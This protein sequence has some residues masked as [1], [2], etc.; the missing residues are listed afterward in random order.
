MPWEQE[1]TRQVAG[2]RGGI[3][4]LPISIAFHIPPRVEV[5]RTYHPPAAVGDVRVTAQAVGMHVVHAID[6]VAAHADGGE[7]GDIGHK[8]PRIS[9]ICTY[10]LIGFFCGL[11]TIWSVTVHR[12]WAQ[13][14]KL[15]FAYC[16]K[17]WGIIKKN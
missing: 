7:A 4:H 6:T 9:R 13:I 10:N 17:F 12:L 11:G 1:R 8:S 3:E 16:L 5:Q 2:Q 14:R 15:V